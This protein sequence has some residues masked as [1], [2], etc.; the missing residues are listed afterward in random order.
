MTTLDG[1]LQIPSERLRLFCFPHAGAGPSSY[2]AWRKACGPWL[3]VVPVSLP[4]REGRFSESPRANVDDLLDDVWQSLA[5]DL[6][7]PFALL[8]H[9]MGALLAYEFTRR[10]R[11]E[12]RR[13]PLHLFVTAF[14]A[15][16]LP[17]HRPALAS[18]PDG[19]LQAEMRALSGT[20]AR[21]LAEP[22]LMRALLPTFRADLRACERYWW[23][24]EPPLSV[25]ITCLGGLADTRVSDSELV[26]WR[27][28]TS[29]RF[30]LKYLPGGH[31]FLHELPTVA[32][33]IVCRELTSGAH[34]TLGC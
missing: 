18:L 23:R 2:A 32:Q 24:P 19:R 33:R 3:D 26:A 21:V 8:G 34:F 10:L 16:H 11:R 28:H 5:R 6:D 29:S 1:A 17:A 20:P 14:R 13:Q 12:R 30:Q 7:R 22:E 9:S 27:A 4:G 25:S 15:P 31:F